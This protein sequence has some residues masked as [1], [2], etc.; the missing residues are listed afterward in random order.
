MS[1]AI[2]CDISSV[3]ADFLRSGKPMFISDVRGVGTAAI[4]AEFP[5]T[6]GSY[7]VDG[8]AD[9]WAAVVG[10]FEAD[11]LSDARSETRRHVLGDF[12]APRSIS[13]IC[14]STTSQG[15][16]QSVVGS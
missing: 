14:C 9:G 11:A 8:S 6:R 3:P 4:W 2:L 15:S 1:D 16:H 10:A 7:T 13:S 12:A 5:T